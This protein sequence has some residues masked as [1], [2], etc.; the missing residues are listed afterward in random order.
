MVSISWRRA[1]RR[2][3]RY[4]N[5]RGINSLALCPD[6]GEIEGCLSDCVRRIK[7]VT[8]VVSNCR[9]EVRALVCHPGQM[10]AIESSKT[11]R[12]SEKGLEHVKSG[13]QGIH[14]CSRA[15]IT[16]RLKTKMVAK[17]VN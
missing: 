9:V 15:F 4:C 3:S 5:R 13:F 14:N 16:I 1:G 7:G 8:C 11:R 2:A 10:R 6:C 17:I 12:I